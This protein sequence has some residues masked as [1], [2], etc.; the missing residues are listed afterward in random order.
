L[1]TLPDDEYVEPKE[2]VIIDKVSYQET[3]E[4]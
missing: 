4:I 1:E 3:I 2:E